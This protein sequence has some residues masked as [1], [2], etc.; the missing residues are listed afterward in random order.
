MSALGGMRAAEH[1]RVAIAVLPFVN[2]SSDPEQDYFSDGI[3]E[4]IITDLSR[5]QSLAVASR[6]STSRFKGKPVDIQS[7]R[8]ALGA[9]FLVEGSVRRMGERIGV[10]SSALLMKLSLYEL[11]E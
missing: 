8:R 10:K 11:Y 2:M 4:D 5:W 3:T 1:A 7:V 6:N 9:H